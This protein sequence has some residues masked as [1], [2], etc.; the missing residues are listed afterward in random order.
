MLH[1]NFGTSFWF[2]WLV[3]LVIFV[4]AVVWTV[5]GVLL[6]ELLEWATTGF[7]NLPGVIGLIA[8]LLMWITAL[9]PVRRLNFEVFLYTHQLYVIFIVFL[10]LHVAKCLP[11]GT[12]ELVLL[13]KPEN[14]RTNALSFVFLQV[15]ELSW[16]QWHP[17][18]VSSSPLDGPYGHEIPYHMMYEN[19]ILVAGGIGISPFL[20]VLSDILHSVRQGKPCLPRNILIVWAV[21]RSDELPLLSAIVMES[22]CPS[23]SNK[24]N[25]QTH[26]YVTREYEPPLEEG[27]VQSS[28]NSSLCPMSKGCGMSSLVGTGHNTW[29]GL[30]VM[31]ST[32]GF[33]ILI[34]ISAKEQCED[35]AEHTE[36]VAH[37]DSDE[38][39]LTNFTTIRYGARPDFNE[40]FGT[41]SKNLGHVNVGVIVCGPPTLQSSVAKEIRSRNV[42][43]QC[44]DP[45]FHF[46]SHSFTL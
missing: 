39:S 6:D 38:E 35:E 34:R 17:F 28:I 12:V 18:S 5:E 33:V 40:I 29:S 25:L 43:R 7:A 3:L 46:N 41:V 21:K 22:T 2:D 45:I 23:F 15:R 8:G 30:Y 44:S 9:P 4:P 11:C 10:A 1:G 27:K 26:I 32:A 24:L 14:L 13:A 20:A 42:T 37:R 16:L 19:L 31:S 36:T